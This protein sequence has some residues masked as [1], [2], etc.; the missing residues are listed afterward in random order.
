MKFALILSW[1]VLFLDFKEPMISSISWVSVGDKNIDLEFWFVRKYVSNDCLAL[2]IFDAKT[3]PISEKYL[4][5]EF[6]Q[7][8][9]VIWTTCYWI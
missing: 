2:G 1:P 5:T 9:L 6:V 3:S 4:N 7:C 8:A